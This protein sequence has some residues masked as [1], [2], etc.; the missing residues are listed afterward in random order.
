MSERSS[1]GPAQP[2]R[3]GTA[4]VDTTG[5]FWAERSPEAASVMREAIT[6]CACDR[7]CV[8]DVR[9]YRLWLRQRQ[10][11]GEYPPSTFL[12]E[13][14]FNGWQNALYDAGLRAEQG[15]GFS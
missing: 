1:F 4:A 15:N 3:W 12:I 11:R 7:G 13:L 5:L 10:R 6:R 8:P 14:M 9:T 2:T